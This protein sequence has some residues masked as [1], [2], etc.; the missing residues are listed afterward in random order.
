MFPPPLIPV[1]SKNIK[2]ELLNLFTSSTVKFEIYKQLPG[3][4]RIQPPREGQYF[5]LGSGCLSCKFLTSK[6]IF[7]LVSGS[8]R[9]AER[10]GNS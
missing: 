1:I 9:S 8:G 3:L 4:D 2:K 7:I 10:K 5:T 6:R